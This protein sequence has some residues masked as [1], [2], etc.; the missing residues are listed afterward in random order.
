MAITPA[1]V[2]LFNNFIAGRSGLHVAR[3]YTITLFGGGQ[4]RFTDADFDIKGNSTS[5]LVNGFS[6]SSGAVRVDQKESK[7]QTHL[8]IGTDTGPYSSRSAPRP[9]SLKADI[10]PVS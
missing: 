5:P 4:L 2:A 8:K 3:L 7:T 6:Y 9:I 10:L 1:L